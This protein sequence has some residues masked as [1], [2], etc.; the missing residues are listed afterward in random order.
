MGKRDFIGYSEFGDTTAEEYCRQALIQGAALHQTQGT[1][2]LLPAELEEAIRALSQPII[3][4]DVQ[5]GNWFDLHVPYPEKK[6]TYTRQSRRQQAAPD[7]PLPRSFI[8][9]EYKNNG[10]TFGVILDTSGSMDRSLLAKALGTIA[11]YALAHEVPAVRL[12]FCDA[13]PYDVGY[14]SPDD[15]LSQPVR[16]LGRG[17]T[18]LAPAVAHFDSMK[19]FPLNAPLLVLTDGETDSFQ[20]KRTHAFVLP[21]GKRL[22][23]PAADVFYIS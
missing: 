21:K 7:T 6:R 8:A 17:G 11:H 3:P 2:G 20:I 14:V 23:F 5:L 1:R 12:V 16:V 15:L 22:P 9:E 18:V 13:Q 4:W 19:D 10:H